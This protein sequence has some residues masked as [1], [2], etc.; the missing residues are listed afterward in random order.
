MKFYILLFN[1]LIIGLWCED[2]ER[3][4][5][6]QGQPFSFD[7]QY[8]ESVYFARKLNQWS[9]IEENNEIYLY[10]NFNFNYLKKENIL[11]I[12]SDSAESKHVGFY[13]CKKA[14]GTRKSMNNIYQLILAGKR[15]Y[16]FFFE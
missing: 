1:L 9:E 15:I 5:I 3:V 7:C 10:L 4:I 14:T 11:R 13:A 2:I 8:D 16:S 12:T 6:P